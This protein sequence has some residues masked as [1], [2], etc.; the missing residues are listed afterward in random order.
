MNLSEY[1]THDATSLAALVRAGQ[2]TARE[3]A[4]LALQAVEAMNGP[5]NAVIETFP[6]RLDALPSNRHADGPLVGVPMLNKD[7]IAEEGTRLEL[8]SV[9]AQGLVAAEDSALVAKLRRA[10]LNNLGRTTTPEL[11][12]ASVTESRIQG[13]TRNPWDTGRTPGGSSGGSAAMVAAGA[14]PIAT[15]GDGGGSIRSPAGHCGLVGLKPTRGRVS[16]APMPADPIAG[17][18]I[19]FVLTRSVRDCAAALDAAHGPV[20]GDA[21]GIP[22]PRRPYVDELAPPARPLRIGFTT[23]AWSG[24]PGDADA[25]AGVAAALAVLEAAGHVVEEARPECDHDALARAALDLWSVNTAHAFDGLGPFLGRTPGPGTLQSTTLALYRRGRTVPGMDIMA[26]MEAFNTANHAVGAF[27]QRYDVLVT[28]TCLSAAPPVGAVRCDPEGPV[29]AVEWS[30]GMN[31]IDDFMPLFNISGHPAISL[32][33]HWTADG[34]PVGVQLVAGFA[35]EATLFQL[36][37][38]FEQALPWQG[39]RPPV[40]AGRP[41]G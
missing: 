8:G 16:S 25:R 10:G 36:A 4:E 1:A 21:Y 37:A 29:D 3:L 14:V 18:A 31:R 7:L 27:F 9:L 12:L 15:G 30:A 26:A 33:L 11:G 32:P 34:L 24:A 19:D 22:V 38:L 6:D 35:D 41:R 13:I 39:R 2:V 23:T 40:H 5:L 17:L 20:P 28:P